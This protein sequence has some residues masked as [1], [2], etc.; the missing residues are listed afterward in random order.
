MLKFFCH[1][2]LWFSSIALGVQQTPLTNSCFLNIKI[3]EISVS[4]YDITPM[5]QQEL[6]AAYLHLPE[7]IVHVIRD[8]GTEKPYPYDNGYDN[9]YKNKRDGIYV[10]VVTKIPLFDSDDKFESGTGWPSFKDI[11]DKDHI[12]IVPDNS[13]PR[14]PRWE[15]IETK[16]GV[17]L[18]HVFDDGPL[19]TKKRY[20]INGAALQF[21]ERSQLPQFLSQNSPIKKQEL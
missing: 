5:S 17:H 1:F 14:M 16:S 13:I 20:C 9:Y 2:L 11:I 4:G 7:N 15:V 6:D 19:P 21:V 8:K 10:S 3:K 18:G 12:K